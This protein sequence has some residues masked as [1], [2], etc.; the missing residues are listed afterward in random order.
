MDTSAQQ[1]KD[2]IRKT[3]IYS[4]IFNYPLT[5]D[6]LYTFLISNKKYTKREI[7]EQLHKLPDVVKK[8]TY[9]VLAGRE[10]LIAKRKEKEKINILKLQKAE[11]IAKILSVVPTVLL[12]GVSGGVA[13]KN[14][15]REDDID[16]FIITQKGTVWMSR[17]LLLI[18][19]KAFGILRTRTT[20][21]LYD[22][23]CL[24]MLI[25]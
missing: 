11:K 16:F 25:D 23:N 5:F 7:E 20:K 13:M 18:L 22:K 17:L 2:A 21:K 6:Q 15:Q 14:A 1:S 9:Y 10:Q 4:D 12:I 8:D 24:N 3:L 19:L